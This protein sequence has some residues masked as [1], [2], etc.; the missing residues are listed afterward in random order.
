M[1]LLPIATI[2]LSA[3]Q[4]TALSSKDV[5]QA[6]DDITD[7]SSKTNDIAKD[8]K[9]ENLVQNLPVSIDTTTLHEFHLESRPCLTSL[10][11]GRN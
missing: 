11:K 2:A 10:T 7:L 1:K 8:L 5:V 9:P 4:A 6:I 3:S